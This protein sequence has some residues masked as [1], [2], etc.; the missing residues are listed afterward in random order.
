M[1]TK[2]FAFIYSAVISFFYFSSS[3]ATYA[4]S[5]SKQDTIARSSLNTI[6]IDAGHG[7]PD[8]G[9][10]G[11]YSVEANVVLGFALRLGERIKKEFP[12]I[13]VVYTRVD[14]NLPQGLKQSQLANRMRADIANKE[15]GDLFISLHADAEAK[16]YKRIFKGYQNVV[17]YVK[18]PKT[19]KKTKQTRRKAIYQRV[20]LPHT[21]IGS[22]VYI[23]AYHKGKDKYTT[24]ANG[25][26][27]FG[28]DELAP[29][30]TLTNNSPE[31]LARAV[32]HSKFFFKKSYLFASL[33]DEELKKKNRVTLGVIQRTKGI[34]VLQASSMPSVLVETGYICTPEDEKL[35]NSKEGKEMI[36]DAIIKALKSYRML[37]DNRQYTIPKELLAARNPNTAPAQPEP[38]VKVDSVL[39]TIVVSGKNL[40]ISVLNNIDSDGSLFSILSGTTPLL[41]EK[42]ISH[43]K[44]H[45]FNLQLP[46]NNSFR[47]ILSANHLKEIDAGHLEVT[48]YDGVKQTPLT[49]FIEADKNVIIPIAHPET[50]R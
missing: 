18:D 1:K 7:L 32:I 27:S 37:I 40:R 5:F 11:N 28:E 25:D 26:I 34:W 17:V 44:P 38:I 49:L 46:P 29:D 6:I 33:I 15:K 39:P 36:V 45:E 48:I 42:T 14:S 20:P 31:I 47:F 21:K 10:R 8:P 30:I 9:A 22:S 43:T 24:I 4:L 3:P 35:I 50:P 13:R 2:F 16:K 23:I 41:T 12:D 19:G